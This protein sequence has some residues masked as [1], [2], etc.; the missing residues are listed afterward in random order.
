MIESDVTVFPEPLSPTRP[1][2]SER[3]TDERDVVDDSYP[4]ALGLELDAQSLDREEL[5]GRPR[6]VVATDRDRLRRRPARP[7]AVRGP[8]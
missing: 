8:W 4:R 2:T 6:S 1:S 3:F 7:T 5:V